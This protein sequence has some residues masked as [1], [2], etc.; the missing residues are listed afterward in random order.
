MADT[1]RRHFTQENTDREAA[2]I[3][4]VTKGVVQKELLAR[5]KTQVRFKDASD[6]E[7]LEAT[8]RHAL[9]GAYAL[10]DYRGY[11]DYVPG[12][13]AVHLFAM[14][15]LVPEAMKASDRLREEKGILANVFV[16]TSPDLLLGNYAYHQN[17]AH[18]KEGLKLDGNLHFHP[19]RG[20]KIQTAAD[21][22]AL[23]G[24]RV[25]IVSSH[26]G[27]PGLLDNIGSIVGVKHRALGVRKTSKSG[28]TWDIYHLHGIDAD[29]IVAAAES[30]LKESAEEVFEVSSAVLT[31]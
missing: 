15:A 14:G 26:D 29:G 21:W 27:E 6:D 3:R 23:Q 24:S 17:Y 4:C 5:L 8:R 2:L 10:I 7:M 16:V 25:P 19:A 22:Y 30:V 31:V 13:N 1:L 9:E 12:D 11:P 18:L 28:T 20:P